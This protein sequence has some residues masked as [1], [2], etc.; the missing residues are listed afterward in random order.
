VFQTMTGTF[1]KVIGAMI[2]MMLA[3]LMPLFMKF[4]GWWIREGFKWAQVAGQYLSEKLPELVEKIGSIIDFFGGMKTIFTVLKL[5]LS[6]WFAAWMAEKI[7]RMGKGAVGGVRGAV[8]LGKRIFGRGAGGAS[9]GTAR[10]MASLYGVK[11]A[12]AAA[13]GGISGGLRRF[14]AGLATKTGARAG[15]RMGAG[16]LAKRGGAMMGGAML[17]GTIGLAGAGVGAVPGAVVGAIAGL[18][19]G[20]AAGVAVDAATGADI[21]VKSAVIPGYSELRDARKIMAAGDADQLK[22][23]A[24]K[25]KAASEALSQEIGNSLDQ[26]HAE[27]IGRPDSAVPKTMGTVIGVYE[28]MT[29]AA[30][31]NEEKMNQKSGEGDQESFWTGWFSDI[32]GFFGNAWGLA[33]KWWG[34]ILGNSPGAGTADGGNPS[35]DAVEYEGETFW[36]D[37]LKSITGFFGS[38]WGIAKKWWNKITGGAEENQPTDPH[39]EDDS[40]E[41]FPQWIKDIGGLFKDG[42]GIVKGWWSGL[43]DKNTE[44]QPK[45]DSDPT[46]DGM[47]TTLGSII[48]KVGDIGGT[49]WGGFKS[50]WN[51][52]SGWWSGLKDKQDENEPALD[53]DPSQDNISTIL[54]GFLTDPIGSITSGFKA[55]WGKVKN[56]WSGLRDKQDENE[57]EADSDPKPDSIGKTLLGIIKDPVGSIVKGFKRGWGKVKGWWTS[58]RTKQTENEPGT[59]PIAPAVMGKALGLI[60][61]VASGA[62]NGIKQGFTTGWTTVKGWWNSMRNSADENKP[63]VASNLV[64]GISGFFSSWKTNIGAAWNTAWSGVKSAWNKISGGVGAA[65][66]AAGSLNPFSS[67]DVGRGPSTGDPSED[68]FQTGGVVPGPVGTLG[69]AA[70]HAGET[71]LPTHLGPDWLNSTQ[72]G[73]DFKR[74]MTGS[75]SGW[76]TGGMN[77]GGSTTHMT[78]NRPTII[79]I[80]TTESAAEVLQGL[81]QLEMLEDAAFFS[82]LA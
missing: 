1:F 53:S 59:E 46:P 41:F 38:A 12:G 17:G 65:L 49:I 69:L 3:P 58:L 66:G 44:N 27:I 74:A 28:A 40:G 13:R 62:V 8:G 73:T 48:G 64:S 24:A 23:E 45:G 56:W 31:V 51:A 14:G 20:Q 2:D 61:G 6:L 34:W 71:I 82:S 37:W 36:P 55:G 60:T 79:N 75:A 11:P 70:V 25:T 81:S 19:I 5:T 7:Y 57:P 54:K 32:T 9:K 22:E 63:T 29:R 18:V 72:G 10:S 43:R 78:M 50:G 47:G 26:N 67:N 35:E 4:L 16:F 21:S 68:Y 39:E 77:G 30:A 15:L 52:V 76:G 33:K 42:W 80:S